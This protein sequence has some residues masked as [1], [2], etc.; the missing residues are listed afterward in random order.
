MANALQN[1][2]TSLGNMGNLALAQNLDPQTLLGFALGRY[3]HNRYE[4]ARNRRIWEK[5]QQQEANDMMNNSIGNSALTV[6]S[7]DNTPGGNWKAATLYQT[8]GNMQPTTKAETKLQNNL[9]GNL[10]PSA[11]QGL[12]YKDRVNNELMQ[13]AIDGMDVSTPAGDLFQQKMRL[14]FPM[15]TRMY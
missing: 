8:I 1:A 14:A 11:A 6:A 3:L 2:I 9:L 5:G 12:S 15:T 7:G 10:E 4:A 13:K